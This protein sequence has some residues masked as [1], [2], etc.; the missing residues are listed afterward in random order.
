MKSVL[1]TYI[2]PFLSSIGIYD[3]S[4][5]L[6]F[7][8]YKH[9]GNTLDN[10]NKRFRKTAIIFTYHRI[11]S[12]SNDPQLLCVPPVLFE[13][14]I[15]FFKDTF[16]II[17]LSELLIRIQ[18]KKL[19]GDEA[20]ITFDDGYQDNLTN[21]L[22]IL[23]KYNVPATIFVTTSQLGEQ[24]SFPWDLKYKSTDKAQF[25]NIDEIKT[26]AQHPLTEI[27][28]HTHKHPS[29][30]SLPYKEQLTEILTGKKILE[31]IIALPVTH[32]AYPFGGLLDFNRDSKK[33]LKKLGFKT[34]SSTTERRVTQSSS[35]FNLPRFNMRTYTVAELEIWYK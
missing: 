11:A 27:G 5:K 17:S 12:V 9:Y 20:V 21:A 26:L 1:Q 24:A 6:F 30:A 3:R 29:L 25:L 19:Q 10:Y 35:L 22:P 31:D 28:A 7:V 14:Q 33:A 13:E 23:E 18:E 4:S 16:E 2:R 34:A 32:F 15:K 8:L